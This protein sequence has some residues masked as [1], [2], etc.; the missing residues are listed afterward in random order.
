MENREKYLFKKQQKEEKLLKKER[1]KR[2]KKIIKF[3][4]IFVAGFLIL[5]GAVF[6]AYSYFSN[7]TSDLASKIEISSKEYDAG[8]VSINGGL[9]TH[10]FEIKNVGEGNLKIN[11]IWTSCMCTVAKLRVGNDLSPEFGMHTSSLLWSK[12]IKPGETGYV[13]VAFDPAFH[14]PTGTGAIT[15][16]I[17]VSTDNSENKNI[18]FLLSVNVTEQ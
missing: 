18:E 4:L 3:S 8:S 7:K 9:V 1:S 17:Y 12:E 6:G 10:S 16:A 14:G 11:K 2:S 5:F 15:R 13:E